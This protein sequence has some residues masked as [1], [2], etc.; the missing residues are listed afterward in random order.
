[1]AQYDEPWFLDNGA[2]SDQWAPLEFIGALERIDEMPR[3]PDFVV[4]PDVWG[5][6]GP[7]LARSGKWAGLV[8]SYGVDY[9]L[10]VQDG[11]PV[12]TG[13]RAAVDIGAA[14]VFVGGTD[15]F[16]REYAGQFVMTAH[17]YGL[18]CHIG[19]PGPS[20]SWARDVGA[21]SVDTSTIVRNG[22]WNRL[23][24]LEATE[25]TTQMTIADGGTGT[26]QF[27]EDGS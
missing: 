4:L 7:S 25:E 19:K 20:L 9:Y 21:D 6:A 10:P 22:Y 14:G 3:E 23:R 18:D 16:T 26:T 13:V 27:E 12:E 15:A 2:F 24:K 5:D 17:D 1:M 11:L 8:A